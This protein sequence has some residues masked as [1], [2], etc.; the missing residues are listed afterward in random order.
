MKH[1]ILFDVDGTL[2]R[3]GQ[4]VRTLF[5][6]V[7]TE[8]FGG[9]GMPRSY[10]FS[11]K[12]DPQIVLDVV[13]PTGMPDD[14]IL[15]RLPRA[16]EVYLARLG[17]GLRREHVRLMPG[18]RPLLERLTARPDVVL[19]L[20]TGNWQRG[21]EVKL[22]RLDLNPYFLFGAYGDDALE[23]RDL[24]PVAFARA[25]AATGRRFAPT[26]ALIVGDSVRDVDCA[27]VAG[28]PSLAVATGHTPIE[29]LR[30][31]GPDWA[32]P[33]LVAAAREVELFGGGGY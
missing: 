31:A 6:D 3:C 14:E 23:R 8:V 26:E 12:T 30:A 17:N 10:D 28:V 11:G 25:A 5:A 9:F 4:Q 2:L 33:D 29:R 7:L 1:L 16:K 19:G 27:R 20:L 24:V 18:V 13:R 21:A 22:S 32:F 15:S